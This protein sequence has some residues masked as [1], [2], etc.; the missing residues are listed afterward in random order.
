MQNSLTRFSCIPEFSHNVLLRLIN[1]MYFCFAIG[2]PLPLK[3][4]L[5]NAL[6]V[7]HFTTSC[8]TIPDKCWAVSVWVLMSCVH[9][10]INCWLY[11][12]YP[13]W[14]VKLCLFLPI[15]MITRCSAYRRFRT[16]YC[17]D[18]SQ[19]TVCVYCNGYTLRAGDACLL[20]SD[21]MAWRLYVL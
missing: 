19:H 6:Y 4:K 17:H 3:A 14:N 16:Y 20:C 7:S 5:T 21:Y 10:L 13:A 1:R 9:L 15:D 18:N 8:I 2:V 11:N 12:F